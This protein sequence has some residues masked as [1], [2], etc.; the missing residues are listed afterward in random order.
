[1]KKRRELL[2]VPLAIVAASVGAF[3]WAL[4]DGRQI[5]RGHVAREDQA[6]EM[7]RTLEAAQRAHHSDAGRFAWFDKL[8]LSETLRTD[9]VGMYIEHAGYRFDALLPA[10][11]QTTTAMQLVSQG[12]ATVHR[13]L[14]TK[15]FV[16]VARPL[17]PAKTGYRTFYLDDGG[18]LWINEGVSDEET[19]RRNPLPI[20]HLGTSDG[21]DLSGRV[22]TR[23]DKLVPRG[24]R[25]WKR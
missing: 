14:R 16:L 1:M 22:W 25:D 11:R 5:A 3:A 4:H 21:K 9:D 19:A 24:T 15:H 7:L 23:K 12:G 20:A 18:M 13:E 10:Q 2:L 8:G 17:Q 6:V